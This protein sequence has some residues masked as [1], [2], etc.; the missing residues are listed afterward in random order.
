MLSSPLLGL[1]LLAA[2]PQE[3]VATPQPLQVQMKDHHLLDADELAPS[4]SDAPAHTA[5]IRANS[6]RLDGE[7][8]SF[9]P[10]YKALYDAEGMTFYPALGKQAAHTRRIH[11]R[12][13]SAAVGG[14][15]IAADVQGVAPQLEDGQVQYERGGLVELYEARADGLEQSF[16]FRELPA[17]DGDLVVTGRLSTDLTF[18]TQSPKALRFAEPGLAHVH[19]DKVLGIDARGAQ[20]EG[21]LE[22]DGERFELR[23]PAEFIA[24]AE[25]PLLLDPVIGVESFPGVTFADCDQA[26]V[27]TWDRV[28]YDDLEYTRF[29]TVFCRYYSATDPDIFLTVGKQY[30]NPDLVELPV[31][32][33]TFIIE[34]TVGTFDQNPTV[35]LDYSGSGF[36]YMVAWQRA[37]NSTSGDPVI[38]ARSVSNSGNQSVTA[39]IGAGTDPDVVFE[40]EQALVA[41]DAGSQIRTQELTS[42]SQS[43]LVVGTNALT[44]GSTVGPFNRPTIS[45]QLSDTNP[46]VYLLGAERDFSQD[47]DLL[48]VAV[49]RFGI[50]LS[51]QLALTSIGPDEE[52]PDLALDGSTGLAVF[53]REAV[54]DD[55]DNDIIARKIQLSE[56]PFGLTLSLDSAEVVVEGQLGDDERTPAVALGNEEWI[57][58]WMDAAFLGTYFATLRTLSK[59]DCLACEPRQTINTGSFFHG[60]IEVACARFEEG[61]VDVQDVDI[62]LITYDRLSSPDQVVQRAWFSE[63]IED[64][65]DRWGTPCGLGP[66]NYAGETTIGS[67][68]IRFSTVVG[69]GFNGISLLN[70][71]GS[72]VPITCGTCEVMPLEIIHFPSNAISVGV[73]G[74]AVVDTKIPCQESLVEATVNVQW[75]AGSLLSECTEFGEWAFSDI[76]RIKLNY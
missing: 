16:Y 8:V 70:I 18:E 11:Y 76:L 35:D 26:D 32:Q 64:N 5:M 56:G 75:I 25:L 74:L 63:S 60:E 66:I 33:S 48:F 46:P 21:R 37:T 15:P 3:R 7:P 17:R 30:W 28:Q 57:V 39:I 4:R 24:Q 68:G 45:R 43:S 41:Y 20:V 9:G 38:R 71:T 42:S 62:A 50:S 36:D 12:F 40:N 6:Q 58:A 47:S 34:S 61:T 51:N 19:I 29:G 44:F 69:V 54:K 53:Q 23:L 67:S 10:G 13:E 59:V 14:R 27:C 65:V 49:D 52:Y 31:E 22:L 1:A 55:G 72:Q 73:T 2:A